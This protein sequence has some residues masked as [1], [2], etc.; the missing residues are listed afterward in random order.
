MEKLNEKGGTLKEGKMDFSMRED[1]KGA[2]FLFSVFVLLIISSVVSAADIDYWTLNFYTSK[3]FQYHYRRSFNNGWRFL[4][5]NGSGTP[6]AA[7]FDDGSWEQVNIPHSSSYDHPDRSDFY[8]GPAWYRKKFA[9]PPNLPA[10]KKVFIEFGGAMSTA[11]VWVNGSRAGFHETNGY[12][13]FVI[14]ITDRVSWTDSSIIAVKV[15]NSPQEDVPPGAGW[16]DYVTYGGIYRNTWLHISDPVYIPQWGQ[17]I[18][19][20]TVSTGSATMNVNTTVVNDEAQQR[21]CSLTYEI[22]DK[23]DTRVSAQTAKQ[24]IPANGTYTFEMTS[25]IAAPELWSPE[26]PN[27]YRIVTTV[28][29]DGEPVDDYVDRF[30]VRTLTWT[31]D[32]GFH[33]NGNRYF[34]NGANL[35]QDFAWVHAAVPVSRYYKMI[36]SLKYAGFNLVR[37]S[38]FP[39]DPAFYDACDEMGI[40]VLTE[41]PTWGWSHMSYT[42]AFWSNLL[43]AFKEMVVQGNNHP[44][45]IGY[46]YFNEPVGDFGSYFAEMKK[47]ADSINTMLPKYVTSNGIRDY[48][49]RSIDFYGNQYSGYPQDIPSLCTE[50]L[51]FSSASR[52][53]QPAEDKYTSDALDQFQNLKRDTRNAGA[54][55]W[56][57]R[58]YWGFGEGG[59]RG[60]LHDSKLG[61]VDHFFIPKRPYYAFREA[62]L[63]QSDDDNPIQGTATKV[64]L[65]PDLTSLRADGTDISCITVVIRDNNG[66]CINS[67]AS[68]TLTVSGSSCTMFGP[69]RVNA[70]AG[71]VG[72]VVRSTESV[73]VT[74]VTA[75]SNG[76]SGTDIEIATYPVVDETTSVHTFQTRKTVTGNQVSTAPMLSLSGGGVSRLRISKESIV[77]VFDMSGR[78]VTSTHG[79]VSRHLLGKFSPG[80]YLAE[81]IDIDMK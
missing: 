50:Y 6:S 16:V 42:P 65:E 72:V 63:S 14:D 66:T 36:E 54:V 61:I 71:K 22:F 79:P 11:E 48:N 45:I 31:T 73:G 3:K 24:N 70:I 2:S 13:S 44:S 20:P 12:T 76:L 37:C 23:N 4:Q 39:R 8:M 74:T 56:T 17:I 21:S 25:E 53:D 58:D 26:H 78:L 69:E 80:V 27:L 81:V 19:T 32:N 64:S 18:S 51:G 1:Y 7:D 60:T 9:L 47:I 5:G 41:A 75:A 10:E 59:G 52:G 55:L 49:M 57:F 30:G 15:D 34:I 68:V 29:V 46:G 43:G 40:L 35:A 33:L 28:G 77:K 62:M 67:D 38:H